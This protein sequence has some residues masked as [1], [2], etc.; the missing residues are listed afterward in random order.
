[1][2]STTAH[3]FAKFAETI[4]AFLSDSSPWQSVYKWK[5]MPNLQSLL[6]LI[7]KLAIF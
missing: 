4:N 3:I 6:L 2:A 1:L 7:K 5:C